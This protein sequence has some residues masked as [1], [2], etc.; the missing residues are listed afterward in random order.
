MLTELHPSMARSSIPREQGVVD[1]SECDKR[2]VDKVFETLRTEVSLIRSR[3]PLLSDHIKWNAQ[4]LCKWAENALADAQ[5]DAQKSAQGAGSAPSVADPPGWRSA[6]VSSQPPRDHSLPSEST[7]ARIP[8]DGTTR[9]A[10]DGGKILEDARQGNSPSLSSS[11]DRQTANA[12]VAC[13]ATHIPKVSEGAQ[14]SARTSPEPETPENVQ[15]TIE[16]TLTNVVS[17]AEALKAE[18]HKRDASEAASKNGDEDQYGP[19]LHL[20]KDLDENTT[21][22]SNAEG[23]EG[24]GKDEE[25]DDEEDEGNEEDN[26]HRSEKGDK[27]G[28]AVTGVHLFR[29]NKAQ[30]ARC[31]W[32]GC[33]RQTVTHLMLECRKWRRERKTMLQRLT[34]GKISISPRRDWTDLK[35]LFGEDAIL[36]V[37]RFIEDT[38][39]GKRL[40]NDTN[41]CDSW[42]IDLLDR[43]DG[44]DTTGI[45]EHK[46]V[47]GEKT[48]QY[49]KH[50]KLLQN[51]L[52]AGHSWNVL[53][54]KFGIGI[55]ALVPAGADTGFSNTDI[56]KTQHQPFS[57]ILDLLEQQRGDALL[58]MSHAVSEGI[59]DT[60]LGRPAAP[61]FVFEDEQRGLGEAPYDSPALIG[62][63]RLLQDG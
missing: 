4:Q 14:L 48:A 60:L 10:D 20:E 47:A 57:K 18:Q 28:H 63:C 37:L 17:T 30:D 44:E 43:G 45:G 51:R 42:D 46:R 54:A 62:R 36:A 11:R 25:K 23:D 50:L 16:D 58:Q 26:R 49:T 15:G 7:T 1:T 27:S 61:I 8:I 41:N 19:D 39:V 22:R 40:T 34:S 6:V 21:R 53:Q 56:E 3:A 52:Y 29:I 33:S 35:T 55:L 9:P 59:Y 13:E 12:R 24:H 32:C 2:T 38:N 5:Q 31:W